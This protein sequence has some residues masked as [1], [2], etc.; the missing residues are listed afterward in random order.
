MNT[1]RKMLAMKAF[2]VMDRDKSG[3]ID[4]TDI[5]GVYNAKFHPDV[6]SGKRTEDDVLGEFL[7]TFETH[8]NIRTGGTKDRSVTKE[9]WVEYYNN[10]SASIDSDQYFEA[11]MNS[12]WN[13]DG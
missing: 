10:I 1:F 8:H 7:E 6:K 12:A 3:V 5:K 2:N 9:E 13:F 4:L 11:M